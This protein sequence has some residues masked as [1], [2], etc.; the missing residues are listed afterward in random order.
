[1]KKKWIVISIAFA[2]AAL[3]AGPIYIFYDVRFHGPQ[4]VKFNEQCQE[5]V[6]NQNLIGQLPSAVETALGKPTSVYTYDEANS[7]TYNYAP[8]PSFPFAKFQAHFKDGILNSIEL[9]DD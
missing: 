3:L 5:I 4:V 2:L 1:M 7:F 6:K 8:H 9:Y